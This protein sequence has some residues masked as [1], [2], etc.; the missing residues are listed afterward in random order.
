MLIKGAPRP[1]V[2]VEDHIR[3]KQKL[4]FFSPP[5]LD[6]LWVAALYLRAGADSES[7]I[8]NFRVM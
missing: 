6:G 8:K 7:V 3:A 2:G 4:F 1:F 5:Q